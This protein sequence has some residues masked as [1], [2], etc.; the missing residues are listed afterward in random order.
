MKS[1][2]TTLTLDKLRHTN[3]IGKPKLETIPSDSETTLL[4]ELPIDTKMEYH[5][6]WETD[7]GYSYQSLQVF[8]EDDVWKIEITSGGKDCDGKIDRYHDFVSQGGQIHK[9]EIDGWPFVSA[10]EFVLTCQ[11][12][13]YARS[14]GY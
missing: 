13:A 11:N 9:A 10:W 3:F 7:E 5:Q 2:F 1:F 4:V 12:D 6:S 14:M 8:F